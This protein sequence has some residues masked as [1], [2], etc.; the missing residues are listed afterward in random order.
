MGTTAQGER[1]HLRYFVCR[2]LSPRPTFPG[3]MTAEE[4]AVM[5]EHVAYWTRQL[6]AGRVVVFGPVADPKGAWGLGVVRAPDLDAVR[7]LEE[8]DPAIRSGRGFR[9]EILPMPQA[10]VAPG[11]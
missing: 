10:V 3:D 7:A 9:Y 8:E 5:E 6:E 1:A 4:R 2:L 11:A